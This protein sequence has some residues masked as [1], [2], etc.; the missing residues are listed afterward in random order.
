M[1]KDKKLIIISL[2]LAAFV[3][4]CSSSYAQVDDGTVFFSVRGEKKDRIVGCSG[5]CSADISGTIELGFTGEDD[6]SG[7]DTFIFRLSPSLAYSRRQF[8]TNGIALSVVEKGV[9][10]HAEVVLQSYPRFV[11]DARIEPAWKTVSSLNMPDRT[12]FSAD[13]GIDFLYQV[14]PGLYAFTGWSIRTIAPANQPDFGYFTV[15]LGLR[16]YLF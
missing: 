11:F 8:N 6:S 9:S 1:M 10:L 5:S 12:V 2:F 15:D 16:W 13:S 3:L 7:S 14:N 4:N